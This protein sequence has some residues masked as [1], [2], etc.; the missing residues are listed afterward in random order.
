MNSSQNIVNNVI[1][2]PDSDAIVD[3]YSDIAFNGPIGSY[4][5]LMESLHHGKVHGGFLNQ[6]K[7]P[8]KLSNASQSARQHCH[9]Q[10]TF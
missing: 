10:P 5:G 7:L 4:L 9:F 8:F 1:T 2:D 3:N 6:I